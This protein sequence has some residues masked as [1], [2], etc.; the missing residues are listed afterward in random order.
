MAAPVD[1]EP[2][3]PD[4]I[5]MRRGRP[6]SS[7]A[8]H[9][10][11]R[12]SPSP[13]RVKVG[14]PFTALDSSSGSAH[15]VSLK[16]DVSSRFPPL[17]QFS[18]LHETGAKFA[19]DENPSPSTTLPKDLNQRVTEALADDAFALSTT[20]KTDSLTRIGSM[21]APASSKPDN[22]TSSSRQTSLKSTEIPPT[23]VQ[24]TPSPVMVSTGTMTS[25]PLQVSEGTQATHS[26]QPI[27]KFPQTRD[28]RSS[29]QPRV[30]DRPPPSND[31]SFGM[32]RTSPLRPALLE[33]R[34][35]SQTTTLGLT[36]MPASSLLSLE[37]RRPSPT[38]LDKTINRSR[39]TNAR[40][41]PSSAHIELTRS[42]PHSR[43]PSRAMTS[44]ESRYLVPQ[45]GGK[46][47]PE[48][49]GS[50]DFGHD[51]TKITSNVEFL[52]AMEEED[53]HKRKPK[54]NSS[55]SKHTKRSSL[56]SIS[57]S[58]TK[59]LLSGR[60]GDAFRRF[61]INTSSS[62]QRDTSPLDDHRDSVLTPIT[63][64]EATDGR[65]D[66]G[67]VVEETEETPAEV[68]REIERRRLSLEERRVA[69]AAAAYK[70]RLASRGNDASS[71][72][73]GG[74]TNRAAL[75]QNKVQSLLDEGCKSPTKTAEGYGR[76][77]DPLHHRIPDRRSDEA[78]TISG[79]TGTQLGG[80]SVSGAR[81]S[82][83]WNRVP[84]PSS[85]IIA[86]ADRSFPLR[87]SAPPK[88]K[89]LRTGTRSE[90]VDPSAALLPSTVAA[91]DIAGRSS[92]GG[93]RV[94]SQDWE[95][96]FSK[97]Y[98]SLSGL[99]MVETEIDKGSAAVGVEARDG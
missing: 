85:S 22:V 98:L 17:N 21:A 80:P 6:K 37:D 58:G 76:F 28:P 31:S 11:P 51:Q 57:L 75:I 47:I 13:M 30:A 96:T 5:P 87:P 32:D 53:P 81:P 59:S 23:Q 67:Q 14:D 3:L 79:T 88:P 92:D 90:P 45:Q 99:E 9:S 2:V 52:R 8:E 20:S 29:S 7:S 91:S 65:S 84:P 77:T 24:V 50:S 10:A 74:E 27:F 69:D 82:S 97:K 94:G 1:E 71:I 43:S 55:G 60:F 78:T 56:P 93:S 63:G 39:S 49:N 89:A 16:E 61:E 70:Q 26:P 4:I 12:P 86:P 18:I 19:F 35:K 42:T 73:R 66:D 64:S 68:R 62:N 38:D 46:E 48:W 44:T 72:V 54:R 34:S 95:A 15:N 33:H 40:N 41:R 36:K 83:S 25:P